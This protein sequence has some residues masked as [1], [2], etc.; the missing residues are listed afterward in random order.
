VLLI[1]S[2]TNISIAC[3]AGAVSSYSHMMAYGGRDDGLFRAA[4]LQ[5]GGAFPLTSAT[6][7]SFQATFDQLV[8]NTVCVSLKNA[9][10]AEQLDCIRQLPIEEFLAKVGRGTGQSID[11]FSPTSLQFALPAGKIVKVPVLV[12]GEALLLAGR[13]LLADETFSEHGRRNHIGAEEHQHNP[14]ALWAAW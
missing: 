4:V 8:D 12:G 7:P 3:R 5:S 1:S 13:E 11:D 6:S 9:T 10:A 2:I 14:A